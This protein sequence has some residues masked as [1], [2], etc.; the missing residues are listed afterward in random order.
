[1]TA[2][3]A[4]GDHPPGGDAK[5]WTVVCFP[6]LPLP[7]PKKFCILYIYN[8]MVFRRRSSKPPQIVDNFRSIFNQTRSFLPSSEETNF[9]LKI[10]GRDINSGCCLF[11]PACVW[12][13]SDPTRDG[14]YQPNV[15]AIPNSQARERGQGKFNFRCSADLKQDWQPHPIDAQSAESHD[16]WQLTYYCY[17]LVSQPKE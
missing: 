11:P 4:R 8:R 15:P 3:R 12:R 6:P 9:G 7:G 14:I 1:M 10:S 5:C 17:T 2:R 16:H 13:M